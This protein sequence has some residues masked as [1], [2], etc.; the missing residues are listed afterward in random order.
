MKLYILLFSL[1]PH[2]SP[3][4]GQTVENRVALVVGNANYAY[5]PLTNP[6]NDAKDMAEALREAGFQVTEKYNL[7]EDSLNILITDFSYSFKNSNT[8]ALFYFAGHGLQYKGNN[9]LVPIGADNLSVETDVEW[10]CV[11]LE[12]IASKMQD[13]GNR[14]N[15]IILDAC[16]SIPLPRETRTIQSGLAQYREKLPESL[17]VYSTAP[18]SVSEDRS[19]KPNGLF[20][21]KLLKHLR[22]PGLEAREMFLQ[23]QKEVEESSNGRQVPN[24]EGKP[25][26]KFYFFKDMKPAVQDTIAA[27]PDRDKDG[28]TDAA[29]RCPD[30][31]GPQYLQGCPD[32]D[33]DGVIDMLDHCPQVFGLLANKGCP[34]DK[35]GQKEA[36]GWQHCVGIS[37]SRF[38]KNDETGTYLRSVSYNAYQVYYSLV[39][40]IGGFISLGG[41]SGSYDL[42]GSSDYNISTR[43]VGAIG[44]GARILN[45]STKIRGYV[46]A[47]VMFFGHSSNKGEETFGHPVDYIGYEFLLACSIHNLGL[48]AGYITGFEQVKGF[49]VGVHYC[50]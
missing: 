28:V 8:V 24:V 50:F 26:Y 43:L 31:A 30:A 35:P 45:T 7:T 47:G 48:K 34:E 20:T 12:R 22:T 5:N 46:F 13:A 9:Y 14:M 39:N 15:I 29:D 3:V 37:Y 1:F 21:E 49:A 41:Y 18:G 25:A 16:R 11:P 32:S 27:F 36:S 4:A 40:K 17:I 38:G 2:L 44:P 10:R 42:S 6:V 19:G 33:N 23:V